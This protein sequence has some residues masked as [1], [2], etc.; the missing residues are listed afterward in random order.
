MQNVLLIVLLLLALALICVVLLQRSEG[1]G[2]G[3]GAGG[4][5]ISQRAQ[6]TALTRLTWIFGA[7]FMVISLVLTIMAARDAEGTSVVDR[8]SGGNSATETDGTPAPLDTDSL[9]PP[10]VAPSSDAPAVP[11]AD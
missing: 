8:I 7:A 4:G 10:P 6:A 3:L 5:A 1:G 2:M 11:R 9:L